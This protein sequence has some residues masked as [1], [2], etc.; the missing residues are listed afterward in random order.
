MRTPVTNE[1][2]RAARAGWDAF[3]GTDPRALA[4]MAATPDPT[5]PFLAA[6]LRRLL[7]ELPGV[8]DGLARTERQLLAA[9]AAGARTRERAFVEA[10]A[11]EEAPFLGDDTA[12][13]R[14][15]E[16][17]GGP[18]PLVTAGGDL[19]LTAA[20]ADV[21]AGRADRVA[22]IGFDRWLGGLH[23]RAEDGLW[24]WDR[25]RGALVAP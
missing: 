16:L 23:L 18:Q 25:E 10:A 1:H 22:L 8:R 5:L 14:L 24:R 19:A 9:I 3:R 15:D 4:R 13:E 21:L 20:G 7:E 11:S 6:A 17:A 2:V 12:F